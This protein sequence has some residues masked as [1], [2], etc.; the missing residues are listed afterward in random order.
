MAGE[1][2]GVKPAAR[3]A[4]TPRGNA[5]EIAAAIALRMRR[6]QSINAADTTPSARAKLDK[7]AREHIIDVDHGVYRASYMAL[8]SGYQRTVPPICALTT[9]NQ[10]GRIADINP[11]SH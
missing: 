6:R 9:G 5:D 10:S 2:A 8:Y 7:L 4:P 3:Q 1:L 11:D